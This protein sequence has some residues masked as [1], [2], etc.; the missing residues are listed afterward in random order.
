MLQSADAVA[1][2][3]RIPAGAAGHPVLGGAFM[4]TQ[5]LALN[6]IGL[7]TT[8]YII[9]RLGPLQYGQWA[10]A[11]ALASAHL[12]ITNAGLRTIFVRE[13]ARRP[14]LAQELLTVQ[15]AVRIALAGLAG[16]SAMSISILLRYPPVVIAC[17]AVG[18]VWMV[19]SVIG[20]TF[21]DLL[22]SLE[23]FGS[24]SATAFASGIAVTISSIVAVS[25]GCGPVGL[26]IAYLAAPVVSTCLCW[27][28][29]RKHVEVRVR[30]DAA[31]AWSLLREARLVGLNQIAGALR[32]RT[33]P[34]LVPRLLGVEAFGILSAGAMIGDRLA[35]V[36]D[37]ICTAFYPRISR[38]AQGTF[39]VPPEQTVA[40]MLSVGLAASMPFAIIGTYLAE[41][42]SSIL[43]P[44]AHE[45]CRAIIQVTV[46]SVP[47]IAISLGLSF[48]LQAAGHHESVAR[49]GLR[50]T[51]VSAGVSCALIATFGI[52]GASWAIV[53]RPAAVVIALLP[54]FRKTFP[55]VLTQIP[56][57]RIL[58]S[59]TA[60]TVV[61]LVGDRERLW[62]ALVCALGG[63]T[64]Y[65]LVLLASRVFSIST[66]VGLFAP[67][68]RTI[69]V[70]LKS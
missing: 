67:T 26:S 69:A 19:I 47:L 13:V 44:D 31:R 48:A 9:R 42:I 16:G 41:S 68:V 54:S 50:A 63:I 2:R 70:Q 64:A 36:P 20:S 23:K 15:L 46:W 60:L 25:L 29:V 66:V 5:F 49:S 6:A 37:A 65:S 52:N 59:A 62:I 4:A 17:T 30:W 22:Q 39:G 43:L 32:D 24:Y 40:R 34:L 45:T 8:A 38:A 1:P 28:S 21:G 18:C 11:A 14:E 56:F 51:A 12:V 27:R 7:F 10:T 3:A 35:N 55:G 57:A 53:A 33:E 61:C 58:L